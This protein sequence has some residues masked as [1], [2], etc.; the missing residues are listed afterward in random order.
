MIIRKYT[1]S[2]CPEIIKLFYD[3][4]H[5]VNA[6]DYTKEQLDAWAAKDTDEDRWNSS[7]LE[8]YTIVAAEKGV[9]V[10]FG[11]IDS[12]GYLDRLYVHKDFQRK[13]IASAIC[14]E[15]EKSCITDKISTHASVTAKPFFEH[16]GYKVIKTRYVKRHGI[17]LRNYLMIKHVKNM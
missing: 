5:T 8:H 16:R 7:F 13:G 14:N 10:G 2:D 12:T 3:T 4:V 17:E 15:L 6:K 1:P 11:D 9:I